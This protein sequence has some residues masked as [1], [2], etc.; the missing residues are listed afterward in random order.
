[1]IQSDI[2]SLTIENH[3][4]H[5]LPEKA[6]FWEKESMLIISD[7]HLG[8]AGHFRKNGIALPQSSND[9]NL[10]RIDTI[11]SQWKPKKILFLGD[12]FHSLENEEWLT[13]KNWR[14]LY[15]EIEFILVL[16]NHEIYP[17]IEYEKLGI[18]CYD[19]FFIKPFLFV[20]EF[21]EEHSSFFTYS[22]HIHPAVRLKGKGRQSIRIPCF[23]FNERNMVL[24]AFGYLTGSYTVRPSKKAHVYGVLEHQILEIQ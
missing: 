4:V 13:F 7:V 17:S 2:H 1:M 3:V 10:D 6:V 24:P 5:L 20:H 22:G 18:S 11:I 9:V 16:G 12:L 15:S 19:E 8:K 23:Y 21:I 14:Q